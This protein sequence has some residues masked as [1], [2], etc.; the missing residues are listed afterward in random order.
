M[1]E[2]RGKLSIIACGSGKPLAEKIL[3]KLVEKGE[4]KEVRLIES[5]E[6]Q[7]ANTEIKTVIGES[8]RDADVYIIQDVENSVTGKTVD[9][10]LRALK[11][12]IDAAW[13]SDA[14]YITAVL[15]VF[16]YARQDKADGRE[17]ITAA[18]VTREIE[19]AGANHVITLDVHNTAIAGF[20]RRAKFDNLHASKNIIDYIRRNVNLKNLAVMPP[21]LGGAKRAEHYAQ[22][23]GVNLV[24]VYKK[25]DYNQPNVIEKA[26]IIGDI[27]GKDVLIVDDMICTGGTLLATAKLAKQKGARRIYSACSL[28]LFNGNAVE[29]MN[30]AYEEGYLH[31]VI[32]T[33]AVHHGG[34]NFQI[35]NPWFK[36]VS[37][38][39]YFA[40]VIHKLNHRESVSELFE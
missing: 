31:A 40:K 2:T 12:A 7:F 35:K 23:L 13:R 24:F 25:R 27:I 4:Y 3:K 16:P 10:N 20:F 15:P 32:G 5:K 18:M 33:D 11:T 9:E 26:E 1:P 37:V 8:I 19:A 34:E 6:I 29:K 22:K 39:S 28:P 21:D 38:A 30:T 14:K 36:E 17:G